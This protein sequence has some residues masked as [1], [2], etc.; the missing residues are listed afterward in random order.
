MRLEYITDVRNIVRKLS[1]PRWISL[2]K[3]IALPKGISLRW[4]I[5]LISGIAIALLSV[6]ATISAYWVVR[7]NLIHDLHRRLLEDVE[8]VADALSVNVLALSDQSKNLQNP[9]G[10]VM[11]QLYNRQG[12]LVGASIPKYEKVSLP[13]ASV[14]AAKDSQVKWRGKLYDKQ[15]ITLS[16]TVQAAIA[17]FN[18]G[19]VALVT[20]T[21]YITQTLNSLARA[22]VS[23]SVALTLLGA[24]TGYLVS[25]AAIRPI[26]QLSNAAEKLGPNNLQPLSYQ[27]ADDEVARLRTVLNDLLGRVKEA[28]DAQR[29]F[30]AETSHELRTP[31]TSLRGFLQRAQRRAP[32]EVKDELND[33]ARISR[34][35]SRLVEDI[36]QLSRGQ[37]VSEYNPYLLNP[38]EDILQPIAEE[39]R[40]VRVEAAEDMLMLGDPERLRQLIRNLTANAVRACQDA[41]QVLLSCQEQDAHIIMQ[42]QD[43]GKGIDPELLPHIFD[44]FYKGAGGGSGLGLAIAKQISETHGGTIAVDSSVGEGT[45]FTIRLPALPEDD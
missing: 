5:T 1:L 2:P 9:T 4:R 11:V 42:V 12:K 29:I 6:L 36:L 24:L 22:L 23:L 8:Q 20:E 33:A 7:V 10:R 39:F 31:L 32:A 25:A 3:G 16:W 43:T 34:T 45:T 28:R 18:N 17:E 15:A 26:R 44:K 38:L 27:G 30:L 19:Y 41:S 14:L 37:V 35:M 40:G 21:A 13:T